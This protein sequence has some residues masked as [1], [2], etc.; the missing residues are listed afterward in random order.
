MVFAT[1]FS[2]LIIEDDSLTA[3]ALAALIKN[4]NSQIDC[5]FAASF[6]HAKQIIE[7][8]KFDL[9]FIDMD[10]EIPFAGLTI[11]PL[12]PKDAHKIVLTAHDDHKTVEQSYSLGAQDFIRK[13]INKIVLHK[14][15]NKFL[16]NKNNNVDDFFNKTFLTQDLDLKNDLKGV[17][18]WAL[19]DVPV[20]I[21][22]PTGVGKTH[23][24]KEI[25]A[26][27]KGQD[28][29]A[30]FIHLS[31]AE[32]PE[33]LFEGELFGY[34]KGAFTGAVQNKKGKLE[35]AHGGTLFLDE[36]GAM[37]LSV[38]QKFLRVLEEKC[39]Y[40]L[41]SETAFQSDFRII[42]ATCDHLEEMVHEKK[43]RSDLFY[44][45]KGEVVRI[46][47]LKNRISDLDLLIDH[48]NQKNF[49]KIIFSLKLVEKF[50]NYSWPGNVREVFQ[51]LNKLGNLEK[52]ILDEG[53]WNIDLYSS[54]LE[55]VS[56]LKG[57]ILN[58][59]LKEVIDE[60]ETQMLMEVFK[61]NQFRV[62]ETMR[63]LKIS[64][65]TFYKILGRAK[66]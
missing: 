66:V 48:Y 46:S 19:S 5:H 42:S 50:K 65:A 32:I 4:C 13:P 57:E 45:L 39:F 56:N 38:Q 20:L 30:P 2:A 3:F 24:A 49:R 53:D 62:R 35:L 22:G 64:N 33:A 17:N 18:S 41:G 12:L 34:K 23:L 11:I 31:C 43:F 25:H 55:D 37:P 36:I 26:R 8:K 14:I 58:R 51:E 7:T 28:Q 54:Q 15:I 6:V 10:L 60:L 16:I 40:P 47:P 29:S 44:R 1:S 52:G 59:G 63:K 9:Y 27:G 61:E 21:L